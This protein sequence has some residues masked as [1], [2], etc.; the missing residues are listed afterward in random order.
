[1][2]D[3]QT[4]LEVLRSIIDDILTMMEN[5]I[6]NNGVLTEDEKRLIS[7]IPLLVSKDNLTKV[8]GRCFKI[9]ANIEK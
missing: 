8:R 7:S 2:N 6:R 9:L 5:K 3:E 1:M 4:K